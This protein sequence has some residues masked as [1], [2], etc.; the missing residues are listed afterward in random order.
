LARSAIGRGQ[1]VHVHNV[2]SA[3]WQSSR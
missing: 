1:L 2:R 3:R